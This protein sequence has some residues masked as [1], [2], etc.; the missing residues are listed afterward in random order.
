MIPPKVIRKRNLYI[1]HTTVQTLGHL[2]HIINPDNAR[3]YRDGGEGWTVLE[4]LCHLRDGDEMFYRRA[5]M[6]C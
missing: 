2:I 5:Q 6:D 4:V 3:T 1:A